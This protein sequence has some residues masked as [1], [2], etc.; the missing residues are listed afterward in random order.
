MIHYLT[1][2][3][4]EVAAY[5]RCINHALNSRIYAYSWYLDAVAD[6]WDVLVLNDY[7]AVM[8]L[9]W[10]RKYC[11]QY[12]YPPAWTQQLGLFSTRK[13]TAELLQKFIKTIPSKFKKIT[14]QFNSDTIF[15]GKN[16][17]ERVNY[18]LPLHPSYKTLESR[19]TTNRKRD[20]K[21]ALAQGLSVDK[22]VPFSEFISFYLAESDAYTLRPD[23]LA[24]LERL[25]AVR[26][27][28][29]LISGLRKNDVLIAGLLCLQDDRRITYLLPVA[30]GQ[31]KNMGL[32]TQLVTAL[33][34]QY[35]GQDYVLDF[36]GSMI[37]G[38]ADF[39]KSF[40]AEREVYY[41]FKEGLFEKR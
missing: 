9:P 25:V 36:E 11:I 37:D 35:S 29:V 38:V 1:R 34:A 17:T 40:G 10:R 8:P 14:I 26:P 21:K 31:A 32:A 6:Q 13:I 22:E 30:N 20:L 27:A 28:S 23:A 3:Q 7:E 15:N 2:D 16:V 5:D 33:L 41:V 18:I 39:Y 19:F 4:L 12:I 24:T